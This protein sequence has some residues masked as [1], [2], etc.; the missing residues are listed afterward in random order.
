MGGPHGAVSLTLR[1]FPTVYSG[2]SARCSRSR[3]T[4]RAGPTRTPEPPEV[5]MSRASG[6]W[7]CTVVLALA[8][9]V[10]AVAQPGGGTLAGKV[11]AA[12]GR[13]EEHTSELQSRVDISYA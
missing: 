2:R 1:P 8:T 3:W 13:S 9:P 6:T 10:T 5:R 7:L 4:R 11:T 12:D